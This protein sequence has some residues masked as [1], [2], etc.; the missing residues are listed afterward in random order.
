MQIDF[1][2]KDPSMSFVPSYKRLYAAGELKIR[3]DQAEAHLVSCDCCPRKCFTNRK[4]EKL[5]TCL[6]GYLPVVS[7][8]TPH[9]GE[10]PVLSGTKGA[11]N[12]FL[13]N[14]NLKCVFCQNYEISQNWKVEKSNTVEFEELADIMIDLQNQGCH[15]IGLVSPTHFSGQI[16]N[17]I[18]IAAGKGLNLPIIYNTNGYDSVRMIQLYKDVID[19][20]LPDLKYGNDEYGKTYSKADEYFTYAR[21]AI[22]EMYSQVGDQLVYENDVVVRGLII[23]HLVLPNDLSETEEVFKFISRELSPEIHISLMSQYYPVHKAEKDILINRK[24]RVREYEKAVELMYKYGLKNG[25]IQEMESPDS[26]RP[27]FNGDRLNPFGN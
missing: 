14:C 23:R 24:L 10:E 9:F 5:G 8:Y 7:S 22:T 19:I 16:L 20:Y 1:I 3:A 12:I 18:E 15:N 2:K 6:S 25:W 27:E 4:K 11:G 21:K 26:Y 13:G 17:S